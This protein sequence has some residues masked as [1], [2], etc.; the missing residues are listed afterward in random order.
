MLFFRGGDWAR[1]PWGNSGSGFTTTYEEVTP[2]C[3]GFLID[4]KMWT[5]LHESW[6]DVHLFLGNAGEFVGHIS[7]LP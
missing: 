4:I 6:N 2:M 1:Y 5:N 3:D 7:G